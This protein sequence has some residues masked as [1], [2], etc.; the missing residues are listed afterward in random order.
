MD[1]ASLHN[2]IGRVRMRN[3]RA[4]K[5]ESPSES[6]DP[7]RARRPAFR[8]RVIPVAYCLFHSAMFFTGRTYQLIAYP[9]SR[10]SVDWI[11]ADYV[12][13]LFFA[14]SAVAWWRN[15]WLVGLAFLAMAIAV[16]PLLVF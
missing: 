15:H 6:L 9:G 8:W 16:Q 7:F 14:A 5:P 4:G 13:A 2:A 3:G 10:A 11:V 12:M 1:F